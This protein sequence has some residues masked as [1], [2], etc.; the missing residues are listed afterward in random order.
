MTSWAYKDL[1]KTGVTLGICAPQGIIYKHNWGENKLG[2][3][4]KSIF[5]F[6]SG[7]F[8]FPN[9]RAWKIILKKVGNNFFLFADK[10]Y[11]E[12]DK[13]DR[14]TSEKSYP[15]HGVMETNPLRVNF[16]NSRQELLIFI[17]YDPWLRGGLYKYFL[18][19]SLSWETWLMK[20]NL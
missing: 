17:S 2:I 19:Y 1:A 11:L 10:K 18:S 4:Y 6:F 13:I 3:F 14:S 20:R 15:R 5:W 9:F 16:L 7:M 12:N 8:C